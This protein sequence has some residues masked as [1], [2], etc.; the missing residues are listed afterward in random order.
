MKKFK[1]NYFFNV[2]TNKGWKKAIFAFLGVLSI[3]LLLSFTFS[4]N[5]SEEVNSIEIESNGWKENKPGSWHIT[6][7]AEWTSGTSAQI[8]FDVSTLFKTQ[9]ELKNIILILDVSRNMSGDK[10]SKVKSDTIELT[11][12]VLSNPQNRIALITFDSNATIKSEFTNDKELIK[13]YINNLSADGATNYN[14]ALIKVGAVLKEY[15]STPDT[16]VVALFLTSGYPTEDTPNQIGEYTVLKEK[17]PNLI[18]NG[19]QYG[20]SRSIIKEIKEISDNQYLAYVDD[21]ENVLFDA[22]SAGEPYENFVIT[23]SIK[24]QNFKVNSINDIKVSYGRVELDNQKQE[25]IWHLSEWDEENK[26]WTFNSGSSA[27]MTI[28]ATLNED[29]R[30]TK[31]LFDTNEGTKVESN[32]P[33]NNQESKDTKATP[34]LYN[35][36]DVIYDTNSPNSCNTISTSTDTF[37]YLANVRIGEGHEEPSCEGYL[38]KGWKLT[39]EDENYLNRGNETGTKFKLSDNQFKM[40]KRTINVKAVWT[41]LDIKKS[42]TG[43]VYTIPLEPLIDL[44][45]KNSQ[46]KTETG[47]IES[48]SN[49]NF[50]VAPSA[51]NGQG[52]YYY[53]QSDTDKPIY[54]YRGAVDNNNVLF[55]D[56]CWKIVRTTETGGIKL[57]YNGVPTGEGK[58]QCT[59]ATG[60]L[61][62]LIATGFNTY[63]NSPADVGYMYGTRYIF[64]TKEVARSSVP[65]INRDSINPSS[66]Y[67]MSKTWSP[68]PDESTASANPYIL[69]DAI[70]LG[71]WENIYHNIEGKGY[72]TCMKYNDDEGTAACSKLYYILAGAYNFVYALEL[73]GGNVLADVDTNIVM[74]SSVKDNKDGTYSLDGTI[75]TIKKS[76]WYT[77]YIS[78]QDKYVCSDLNSS[79][80]TMG[81]MY[82]IG[83]TTNYTFVPTYIEPLVFGND[84]TYDESTETY[85]LINYMNKKAWSTSTFDKKH[86]F[87]LGTTPSCKTVYYA[88]YN[89]DTLVYYITLTGGKTIEDALTEMLS[90]DNESNIKQYIEN[91]YGTNIESDT[92]NKHYDEYL[93]DAVWCNDRSI[94]SYGGWN[95]DTSNSKSSLLYFGGHTNNGRGLETLKPKPALT[96][97]KACPN[98]RDRFT[99]NTENGNGKAK[100]KIGLLTADESTVAGNGWRGYSSMSYLYTNRSYWTISPSV[101]HSGGARVFY[102]SDNG[103][104]QSFNTHFGGGVRPAISLKSGI[105][106]IATG[107]GTATNPYV[108]YTK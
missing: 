8:K 79:T 22:S 34:K 39:E 18:I 53:S 57:I 27:T 63:Y 101:I 87:C 49:I 73:G 56:Y 21:P 104:M 17:H 38:F 85:T 105:E 78:Y 55:A 48:D 4:A 82:Y 106:A 72:Y 83:E 77:N 74:G 52:L 35:G 88:Y 95:K 62:D 59:A 91:W 51:T 68:N 12:A 13:E 5:I 69:D 42:L 54:Y 107:D 46:N 97:E 84:V 102:V 66:N 108:I 2:I 36:Y 29:Q 64:S 61:T 14:D 32:F 80:C 44:M 24:A 10:L 90:N 25:I 98:I 92:N 41:K 3:F 15:K 70:Q 93:E 11:E 19:I 31:G 30:N 99:V 75:T 33:N 47:E 103:S 1:L 45:F 37:S 20:T 81:K 58:N 9:E 96:N 6:K 60:E 26:T 23:D 7:S 43:K 94:S 100:Q 16:D 40:P 67:W 28:N 86:Y 50:G 89:S 65:I 71:E 76:E